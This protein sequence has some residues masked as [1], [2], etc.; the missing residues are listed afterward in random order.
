MK[1]LPKISN[2]DQTR[3]QT[4]K[5]TSWHQKSDCANGKIKVSIVRF[6][7]WPLPMSVKIE[8]GSR[9]WTTG[10]H[11]RAGTSLD[12]SSDILRTL[13]RALLSG[14]LQA[15]STPLLCEKERRKKKKEGEVL[16]LFRCYTHTCLGLTS[17]NW[18]IYF[19]TTNWIPHEAPTKAENLIKKTTY[20]K[21]WVP[22]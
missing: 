13:Q 18:W 6:W 11:N 4:S 3:I 22:G 16:H 7:A 15:C 2:V 19:V 9:P 20:Q 5:N 14:A 17:T 12:V 10:D 21:W 1:G 8:V